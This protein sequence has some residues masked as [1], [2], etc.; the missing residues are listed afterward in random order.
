MVS[1]CFLNFKGSSWKYIPFVLGKKNTNALVQ[2]HVTSGVTTIN[3]SLIESE[4]QK[5]KK[6]NAQIGIKYQNQE[7]VGI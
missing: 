1:H 2:S 7:D 4:M 5:K 6:W 3:V